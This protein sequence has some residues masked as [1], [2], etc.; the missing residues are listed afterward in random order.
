MTACARNGEMRT[1]QGVDC[2]PMLGNT[3]LRRPKSKYIM[4]AFAFAPVRAS[5]KLPEMLILVTIGAPGELEAAPRFAAGMAFFAGNGV[6]QSQQW[7][8][9]EFMVKIA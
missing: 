4:T 6:V 5:G 3:E 8:P 9:S 1:G 7:K 2:T